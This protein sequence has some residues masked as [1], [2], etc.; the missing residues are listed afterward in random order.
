MWDRLPVGEVSGGAVRKVGDEKDGPLAL[1]E[2][3]GDPVWAMASAMVAGEGPT[4]VLNGMARVSV[5]MG[6]CGRL[7]DS[8]LMV[9]YGTEEVSA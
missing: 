5:V 7:M 6:S 2:S 3:V 9:G 1:T 4:A 8:W